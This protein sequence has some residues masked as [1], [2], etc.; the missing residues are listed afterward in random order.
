ME[1]V[2]CKVNVSRCADN[3]MR[4]LR[5]KECTGPVKPERLRLVR[6]EQQRC[7]NLF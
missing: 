2:Y 6:E 3:Q 1:M 4:R 7:L 5:E